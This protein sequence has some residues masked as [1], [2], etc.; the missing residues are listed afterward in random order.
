MQTVG[1][2]YIFGFYNHIYNQHFGQF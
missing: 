2:F 1:L